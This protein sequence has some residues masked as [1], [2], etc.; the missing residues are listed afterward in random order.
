MQSLLMPHW[1]LR[2]GNPNALSVRTVKLA[3]VYKRQSVFSHITDMD[4]GSAI[5]ICVHDKYKPHSCLQ[6]LSGAEAKKLIRSS[7]PKLMKLVSSRCRILNGIQIP[8]LKILDCRGFHY[9]DPLSRSVIHSCPLLEELSL[10]IIYQNSFNRIGLFGRKQ[11]KRQERMKKL[12]IKTM[13]EILGDEVCRLVNLNHMSII[14]YFLRAT[15]SFFNDMHLLEVVKFCGSLVDEDDDDAMYGLFSD[16]GVKIL[17]QNN[18]NLRKVSITCLKLTDDTLRYFT[19]F[20]IS[21]GLEKLTL[22]PNC[23]FTKPVI[24]ILAA[25]G[26]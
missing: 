21:H 10:G 20:V 3:I 22:G 2:K 11:R 23:D 25:A 6:L 12:T 24:D 18:P 4:M 5:A 17:L 15:N 16:P 26:S 7:A 13:S 1:T 9:P 19:D 14:S 8:S